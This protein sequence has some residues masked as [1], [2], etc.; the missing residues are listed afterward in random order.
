MDYRYLRAFLLVARYGNFTKAAQEL[1]IAQ[2]AISR[3]IKLLETSLG[4]QLLV[5]SPQS[6]L[7][8]PRGQELFERLNL[9]DQWTEDQFG[10]KKPIVRI[11]TLE[12]LLTH[13]LTAEL[14]HQIHEKSPNFFID[15][16]SE[17]RI[18]EGLQ[19]GNLDIGVLTKNIQSDTITSVEIMKERFS[20]VSAKE[21][22]LKKLT[23]YRWVMGHHREYMN[24]VLNKDPERFIMLNSIYGI[25]KLVEKDIGI[26]VVPT[27]VIPKGSHLKQYPVEDLQKEPVYMATLNY[28]RY[29]DYLKSIVDILRSPI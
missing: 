20:I 16:T 8:T 4:V 12:G 27:H 24:H 13:W 26:A 11:G 21:I 3:Q 18:I 9:F 22:D 15:V 29:P 5:R 23:S 25:L 28:S 14:S 2:S 1:K 6:V 10:T 19:Q 17:D 7:L